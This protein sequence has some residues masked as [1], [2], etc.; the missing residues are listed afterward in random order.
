MNPELIITAVG[1]VISL[2]NTVVLPMIKKDSTGSSA[3][4]EV[5]DTLTKLSP[6]V[7][8]Q[9]GTLYT[10]IKN[11]IASVGTHPATTDEQLAALMAFDKQV[12][13]AWDAIE[14]DFDPDA[15]TA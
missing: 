2:I 6:L 11:I 7:T 5:I 10:G 9:V 14:K 12:D 8:D 3:I 1:G 13:A 4:G 15:P